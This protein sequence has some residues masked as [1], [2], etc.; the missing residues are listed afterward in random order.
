MK[1]GATVILVT[2]PS[3]TIDKSKVN[4]GYM[5]NIISAYSVVK[6]MAVM[7]GIPLVDAFRYSPIQPATEDEYQANDGLHMV[8]SGYK[9]FAEYM[10][11][12]IVKIL[13]KK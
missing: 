7:N 9:A 8:E 4:Y 2:P 10:A 13:E 12:E 1:K 6:D 11:D 3:A 5:N